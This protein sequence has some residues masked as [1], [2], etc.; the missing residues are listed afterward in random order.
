MGDANVIR[1][2]TSSS[3]VPMFSPDGHWV[4]F[5]AAGAIRK[6]AV[7]GGPAAKICDAPGVSGIAWGDALIIYAGENAGS[8]GCRPV[9]ERQSP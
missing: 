7:A 4:A 6:V 2:L 1:T 5:S 8:P 9:A 3:L